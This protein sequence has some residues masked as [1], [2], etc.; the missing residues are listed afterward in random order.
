MFVIFVHS[1]L[2]DADALDVFRL[3]LSN[4]LADVVLCCLEDSDE[5]TVASR[6]IGTQGANCT[7]P[8]WLAYRV[9]DSELGTERVILTQ[10]VWEFACGHR[11]VGLWVLT[12][13]VC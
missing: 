11:E 8:G 5:R 7:G 10:E 2:A 3:H 9:S 13:M 4:Y 6:T 12:P 1:A